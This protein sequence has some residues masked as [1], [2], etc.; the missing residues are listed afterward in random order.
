MMVR[1]NPES[2][3]RDETPI[4]LYNPLSED[5]TIKRLDDQNREEVHILP[6]TTAKTY[7]AYLANYLKNHLIDHI[8]NARNIGLVTPEKRATIEQEVMI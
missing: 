3:K 8:I 2:W 1:D 7:P 5:V 6:A 4:S